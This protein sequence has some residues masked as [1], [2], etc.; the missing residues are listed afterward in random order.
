[1][2]ASGLRQR[3]DVRTLS[4]QEMTALTDAFTALK[5]NGTYDAFTKRHFDALEAV[6]RGPWFGPWH[7]T[8]LLELEDALRSLDSSL[9][10]PYWRFEEDAGAGLFTDQGFGPNGDPAYDQ[11]VITGPFA[12]WYALIYDASTGSLTQRSTPGLVRRI[13]R[14]DPL[15]SQ[16]DIATILSKKYAYDTSPWDIWSQKSFRNQWEGFSMPF[17]NNAH[18]YVGGDLTAATSPNDPVFFLIHSNVDRI[19]DERQRRYGLKKDYAGPKKQRIKNP[20]P[21]LLTPTTPGSVMSTRNLGY[22]YVV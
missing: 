11:R 20:M 5:Q 18:N 15:P 4:A 21:Y 1:V 17:H 16:G 6:H 22:A 14:G 13:G 2:P 10:V 12:S 19:W 9:T 3:R 8:F 7:R